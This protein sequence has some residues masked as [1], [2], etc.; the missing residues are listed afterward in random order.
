MEPSVRFQID[1]YWSVFAHAVMESIGDPAKF[2]NRRFE[3]IGLYIEDL[4]LTYDNGRL[5]ARAGKLNTGFGTGWDRAAG[6]YGTDFAEDYETSERIGLFGGWQLAKGDSGDHSIWG[7]SFF[8]DTTILSESALRGRGVTRREDGGVSNTES[9]ESFILAINGEKIPFIGETGYHVS[10]MRQAAGRNGTEDE[11][12]LAAAI[13]TSV[14]LGSG[15]SFEPFVEGVRIA[16]AGGIASEDREYLVLSGQFIWNGWNAALANTY[17]STQ[18]SNA[19]DDRDTHFQISA[20]YRFAFGLSVDIG[21][22]TV[23]V[24]HQETRTV[25]ILAAYAI[26][27]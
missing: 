11:T 15:V 4:F 25:G 16:N 1:R 2:E 26:E 10:A 7:G 14:D 21:W 12:S 8:A 17:R 19:A 13:F 22:K 20:G 9:F 6:V 3:D 5:E 27:F 18:R 23:N 24:A